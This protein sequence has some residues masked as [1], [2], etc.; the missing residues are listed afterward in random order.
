[1]FKKVILH[2]FVCSLSVSA[3]SAQKFYH[4]IDTVAQQAWADSVFQS[5]SPE[6]RIGQLFMV[7]AYSN[8]D[9]KH[10]EE[11]RGL[12][13]E[14]NI[15]GLIFFQG[16]PYRQAKLSNEYQALAKVPLAVAMDAEWGVGMRLDS[17]YDFPKQMTLGAIR[18]RKWIYE[19]GKEVA[20]QFKIM[21]MHINFAPVVDV[22][23]NPKNR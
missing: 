23:V 6:E 3:L 19:M 11:I 2:L 13:E 17:V 1:M 21:N 14:Y 20:N 22:N 7:A 10:V 15:G 16:G 18:D 9:Q 12:I 5:L 4:T 8:R